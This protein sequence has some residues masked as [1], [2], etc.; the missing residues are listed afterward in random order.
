MISFFAKKNLH[1]LICLTFFIFIGG[2]QLILASDRYVSESIL[3]LESPQ[4]PTPNLNFQSL[5]GSGNHRDMLLLRE[6][7]LSVDMLKKV[8]KA[9]NFRNHYSDSKIDFWSALPSSDVFIEELHEYY[10]KYISVEL[11]DY[12]G[13]LH[14]K[15]SAFTPQMSHS[16][17]KF[18]ISEGERHMNQMGQ[19]LAEEQV[20]FL[21]NQVIQLANK[22]DLARQNLVSYQNKNGLTSPSNTVENINA[23][24]ASLE[25]QLANSKA[26]RIALLS[27]QSAQSTEIRKLEAEINALDHQI[28]LERARIA[29]KSG[30]AL[31]VISSEYQTLELS[32]QFAQKSYSDALAALENIRIEAARKLKQISILQEPT[33]PEYSAEPRRLYN[34]TVLIFISIFLGLIAHMLLIIIMDH[35]D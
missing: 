16:I 2:Y 9:L 15:V 8:D 35:K 17:A 20:Q 1:W 7:L 26:K 28:S 3:I 33:F 4:M 14:I 13:V 12:A 19:R 23:V 18:L 10:L 32:L 24:I 27:Y 5:I 31:N 29:Q 11:D 21:E 25:A 22:F 6:Y 30:E 34:L